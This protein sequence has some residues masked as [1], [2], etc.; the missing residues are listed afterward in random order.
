MGENQKFCINCEFFNFDKNQCKTD[1]QY[2][3]YFNQCDEFKIRKKAQEVLGQ[4]G[5]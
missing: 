5:N 1:N 4:I 2:V 3:D